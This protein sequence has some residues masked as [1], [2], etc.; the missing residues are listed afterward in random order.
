V[1][2]DGRDQATPAGPFRWT[3]QPECRIIEWIS[4]AEQDLLD[5]ECRYFGFTH[6]RR[7]KFVKP[8]LI[9]ILDDVS[10]PAGEH[11]IEQLWH[12]ES[13]EAAKRFVFSQEPEPIESWRSMVF[14][15]KSPSYALRVHRKRSLP[16]RF[17]AGIVFEPGSR[18]EIGLIE[19]NAQQFRFQPES[20]AART[21]EFGY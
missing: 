4:D 8:D 10:G 15:G 7:I 11:E 1:R 16:A 20:G 14:A 5:A 21:I 6:R 17:A 12:L 3:Q 2:I 19:G 9:L 18:L 13:L